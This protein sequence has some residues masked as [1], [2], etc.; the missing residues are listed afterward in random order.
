MIKLDWMYRPRKGNGNTGLGGL[1]ELLS[2]A[3]ESIMHTVFVRSLIEN[4][5]DENKQR[6]VI[7]CYIP[8]ILHFIFSIIYYTNFIIEQEVPSIK[9]WSAWRIINLGT[10]IFL[11][12]YLV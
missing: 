10:M 8:F 7:F 12:F 3:P 5:Y 6:V 11:V 2:N 1:L 4:F 9:L